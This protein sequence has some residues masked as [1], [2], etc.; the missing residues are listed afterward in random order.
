MNIVRRTM[1]GL[2]YFGLLLLLLALIV[3]YALATG[4]AAGWLAVAGGLIAIV[5]LFLFLYGAYALGEAWER[6]EETPVSLGAFRPR[7]SAGR[8]DD[9]PSPQG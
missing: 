3:G 8:A 6:L 4:T 9:G 2:A 7:A 1:K 5:C